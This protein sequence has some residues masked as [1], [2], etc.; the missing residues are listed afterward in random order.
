[1]D[2]RMT[3]AKEL[4]LQGNDKIQ[5]IAHAVGYDSAPS[6]TRVFRKVTGKSPSEYRTIFYSDAG[7]L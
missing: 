7:V 5:E 3:K 6:F 2:V 1:M 4:L